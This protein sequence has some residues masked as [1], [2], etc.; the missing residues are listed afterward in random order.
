HC[1]QPLMDRFSIEGT[2]R[3]SFAV[4]NDHNEVDR[5][6]EAVKNISKH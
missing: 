4:Y 1:T 6:V 5:L 2:V 3:A